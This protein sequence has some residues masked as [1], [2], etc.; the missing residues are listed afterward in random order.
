MKHITGTLT[1]FL[2]SAGAAHAGCAFENTIP[3]S[4]LGNSFAA[5]KAEAAA[6]EEC[7]NATAELNSDFQD[8]INE[9]L[10][11]DPALYQIVMVTNGGIVS[12]L[13]DGTLRPLND[14]VE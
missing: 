12:L 7:G 2:L 3:T 6:M 5:V 14:L 1:A 11:A 13:N 4:Y 8:K 9:A 10:K